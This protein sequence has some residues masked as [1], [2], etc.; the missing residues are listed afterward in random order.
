MV[1]NMSGDRHLD[2]GCGSTPRNPY[3]RKHLYGVDI[4]DLVAEGVSMDFQY[5]PA[6]LFSQKIPFD[7]NHFSS[8]SAYDFLEH[9]PRTRIK[10]NGETRF[11]FIDV[12][13][14]I[15]RVLEPGGRLF[16]L[17]PFYPHAECFQDP[18]HVNIITRRT[19][20]YFCG[21]RAGAKIYGFKGSFKCIRS[22]PAPASASIEG[23]NHTFAKRVRYFRKSLRGQLTHLIWEFEAV[24]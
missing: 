21:E 22:Q 11:P 6:N 20:E 24:K 3:G 9:V 13:D 19:H 12:M 4:R 23:P 8:V 18:T 10:D 5:R 16:A 17:T 2:L 15:Y 1:Q 7:D 14:E